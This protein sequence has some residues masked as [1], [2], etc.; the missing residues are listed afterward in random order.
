M[1]ITLGFV[2]WHAPCEEYS[3]ER[4]ASLLGGGKTLLECLRSDAVP[5][6]DRIWLAT[7]KGAC[8]ERVHRLFA[9]W[10]ADQVLPLFERAYPGDDR[11]RM[12]IQVATAYADGE[13]TPDEMAA[14]SAAAMDACDNSGAGFAASAAARAAAHT[15]VS[16]AQMGALDASFC[17]VWAAKAA[18]LDASDAWADQ[19]TALI[20]LLETHGE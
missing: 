7:R 4:V 17:A 14:A 8:S 3:R 2:M 13:A 6:K 5:A 1:L 18:K 10:C 9:C 11:P 16:S 19:V 15:D 12:A 20:E